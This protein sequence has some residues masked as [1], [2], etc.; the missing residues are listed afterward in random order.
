M[1][2]IFSKIK[3]FRNCCPTL[4]PD[5]VFVA[6]FSFSTYFN[7][8][9]FLLSFTSCRTLDKLPS[10]FPTLWSCKHRRSWH[11]PRTLH[12][13]RAVPRGPR[14]R[15]WGWE[16]AGPSNGGAGS[17]KMEADPPAAPGSRPQARNDTRTSPGGPGQLQRTARRSLSWER[18][19][20]LGLERPGGPQTGCGPLSNA[21]GA[22]TA[23]PAGTDPAGGLGRDRCASSRRFPASPSFVTSAGHRDWDGDPGLARAGAAA[24]PK[25]LS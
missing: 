12:V 6:L 14:G 16:K 2:P 23:R 8:L 25:K 22:G 20:Q 5:L 19:V 1:S 3:T 15:V 24:Q 18:G 10:L 7:H 17:P 4:S 9:S 13:L 21:T 11:T